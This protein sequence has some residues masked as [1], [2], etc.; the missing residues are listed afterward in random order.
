MCDVLDALLNGVKH[1]LY[2]EKYAGVMKQIHNTKTHIKTLGKKY[3]Q[4]VISVP[5]TAWE[6]FDDKIESSITFT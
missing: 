5:I 6:L 2:E 4:E 3:V 1:C